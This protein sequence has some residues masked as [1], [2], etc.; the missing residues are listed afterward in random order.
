MCF[1]TCGW[2]TVKNLNI[3]T[4]EGQ[5]LSFVCLCR[6]DQWLLKTS[7]QDKQK[8]LRTTK[9]QLAFLLLCEGSNSHPTCTSCAKKS[10]CWQVMTHIGSKGVW[11]KFQF[12][13]GCRLQESS[14]KTIYLIS[15]FHFDHIGCREPFLSSWTEDR[16]WTFLRFVFYC[17]IFVLC[18]TVFCLFLKKILRGHW[19]GTNL[20]S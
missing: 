18:N 2:K 14:E 10:F 12:F 5:F 3:K 6:T 9:I 19:S 16:W 13:Q 8:D 11:I 4:Q 15:I 1:C 17:L 7:I 20:Q